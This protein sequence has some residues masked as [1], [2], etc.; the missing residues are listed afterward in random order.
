MLSNLKFLSTPREVPISG[1][2]RGILD[3]IR[4]GQREESSV[5]KFG[6]EGSDLKSSMRRSKSGG[7]W[8]G[9]HYSIPQF[10]GILTRYFPHYVCGN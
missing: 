6:G 4:N 10:C 1:G 9:L 7:G 2:V 8:P 3:K 5:L